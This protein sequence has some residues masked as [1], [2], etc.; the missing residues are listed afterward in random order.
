MFVPI[1]SLDKLTLVAKSQSESSN[2]R[3]VVYDGQMIFKL[4]T[5]IQ[6]EDMKNIDIVLMISHFVYDDHF[7]LCSHLQVYDA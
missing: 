7:F 6:L 5:M 4:Q 3:F 1:Y 2:L